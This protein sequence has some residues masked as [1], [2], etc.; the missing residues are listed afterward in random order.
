[1]KEKNV[2]LFRIGTLVSVFLAIAASVLYAVSYKSFYDTSIRHFDSSAVVTA[3]VVFAVLTSL[4]VLGFSFC[5]KRQK[6]VEQGA[7]QI[8]SFVLWLCAF[9]FI[10]YG[11]LTIASPA[12][13]AYTVE[14]VSPLAA[15]SGKV[16]GP[17]AL[18]S[19]V[20]FVCAVSDRFRGSFVHGATSFVPVIWGVF[21][22][23]K[24]YFDL[25]EMPLND[26][27]LTVTTL[28]VAAILVFM[29]SESRSA[30]GVA[31]APLY[32]LGSVSAFGI[33]GG[34]S[35]ARIVLGII[36]DHSIPSLMENIIFFS[37]SALALTRI[38]SF[39]SR[40]AEDEVREVI[41][42][43]AYADEDADKGVIAYIDEDGTCVYVNDEAAD[44]AETPADAESESPAEEE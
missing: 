9:M 38:I 16:I 42:D 29:L 20:P 23:F 8:E 1:M 34:I 35:T 10:C 22:L 17:L 39:E 28:C 40:L 2:L 15:F 32:W 5:F 21:L 19:A 33:S 24:Y 37:V 14:A 36:A 31:S 12:A 43:E 13:P 4:F 44:V 41:T 30:L 26:P 11:V 18:L 3:F 6:M 27:E 7:N 25:E